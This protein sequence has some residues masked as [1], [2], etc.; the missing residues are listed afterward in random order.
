M[1]KITV[2][3]YLNT[4]LKPEIDEDYISYPLYVSIT[5]NSKNIKR[6]S[7]GHLFYL[8]KEELE[9]ENTINLINYEK[10]LLTRIIQV[11]IKDWDNKTVNKEYLYFFSNKGYNSKD[12]F[13]NSLNSYIDFYKYSI[14][15]AVSKY[16]EDKID[17]EIY[18]KI[19]DCLKSDANDIKRVFSYNPYIA[20]F[21][22][23]K[24]LLD[25]LSNDGIELLVLKER[26]RSFL[27]P[28]NIETGY[29][30]PYIDWIQNKI[31]SKFQIYL[32][33]Y[34]RRSEY[35]LPNDF[36]FSDELINK[37]ILLIDEIVNSENYIEQIQNSF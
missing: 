11:F 5:V 2:K 29:D 25:N 27:A 7:S 20:G 32:K 4:K 6:R 22:I 37:Y 18:K 12:D 16:C 10:N 36:E 35:Y 19:A 14:F 28:Y 8:A 26:L 9:N 34:K 15:G 33:T 23:E 3:H 31:Q 17:D 13:I 30:I 24:F 21:K 1:G